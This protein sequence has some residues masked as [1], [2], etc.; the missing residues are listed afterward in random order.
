MSKE[1]VENHLTTAL[2]RGENE[3]IICSDAKALSLK[4][5]LYEDS[6]QSR[7]PGTEDT[8]ARC[9]VSASA[10][11]GVIGTYEIQDLVQF[12]IKMFPYEVKE[13]IVLTQDVMRTQGVTVKT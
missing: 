7:I 3:L 8:P 12:L 9:V 13:A 5:P 6:T 2:T 1:K 10:L 11:H 4:N